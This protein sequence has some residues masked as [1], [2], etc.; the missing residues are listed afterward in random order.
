MASKP[1]N[2]GVQGAKATAQHL[3]KATRH[4]AQK[5]AQPARFGSLA[6]R[7]YTASNADA[8]DPSLYSRHTSL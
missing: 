2:G 5:Q 7:G 8:Y 3:L 6:L 1:Y 4:Q